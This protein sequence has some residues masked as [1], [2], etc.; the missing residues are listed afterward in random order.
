M[1]EIQRGKITKDEIT[2]KVFEDDVF[3]TMRND[4]GVK[5]VLDLVRYQI[6]KYA[7][8]M[9]KGKYRKEEETKSERTKSDMNEP[10]KCDAIETSADC[11]LQ[12]E[13]LDVMCKKRVRK[14]FTP[15]ENRLVQKYLEK[16]YIQNHEKPLLKA[17]SESYVTSVPEMKPLLDRFGIQSLIIKVRTERK[18]LK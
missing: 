4:R 6:K 9:P 14:D 2:K 12:E 15:D 16:K 18:K 11:D 1:S 3:E 10:V 17:D 7:E 13:N 8:N 5:K